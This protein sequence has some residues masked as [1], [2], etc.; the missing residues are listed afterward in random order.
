MIISLVF[1]FNQVLKPMGR[2]NEIGSFSRVVGWEV[3][4]SDLS[5]III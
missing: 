2:G 3:K 5:M 4:M 1:M